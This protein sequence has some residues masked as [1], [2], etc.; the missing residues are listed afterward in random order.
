LEGV[1]IFMAAAAGRLGASH[2]AGV[3]IDSEFQAPGM[4]VVGKGLDAR[5]ESSCCRQRHG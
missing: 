5:G 4:D 2:G 3:G 1:L